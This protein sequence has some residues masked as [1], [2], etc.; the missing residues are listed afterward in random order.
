MLRQDRVYPLL[1]RNKTF[2]SALIKNPFLSPSFSKA[3]PAC[4]ISFASHAS[5]AI[6][7]PSRN[8]NSSILWSSSRITTEFDM[9]ENMSFRGHALFCSRVGLCARTL[10]CT[11]YSHIH[12]VPA[13]L[14]VPHLS[15]LPHAAAS[16]MRV[17]RG[18]GTRSRFPPSAH[19]S[20]QAHTAREG[21]KISS[22]RRSELK[23]PCAGE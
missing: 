4:C 12:S 17:V 18:D 6:D 1:K 7:N 16:P 19:S 5:C 21:K 14:S 22:S 8:R 15:I 9:P 2:I 23:M 20:T 11:T 10:Q 3:G 13:H